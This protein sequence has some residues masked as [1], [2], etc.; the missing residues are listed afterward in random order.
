M[1]LVMNRED[2]SFLTGRVNSILGPISV[3]IFSDTQQARAY[4]RE[5]IAD[6]LANDKEPS[7]FVILDVD[8][9]QSYVA[10]G[11]LGVII[12]SQHLK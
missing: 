2:Y 4:V 1:L 10:T 5:T 12:S 7:K 6:E 11:K 9:Y 3:G 8:E